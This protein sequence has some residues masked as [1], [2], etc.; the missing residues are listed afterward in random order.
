MSVTSTSKPLTIAATAEPIK[1]IS[2]EDV[3]IAFGLPIMTAIAWLAPPSAWMGVSRAFAPIYGHMPSGRRQGLIECIERY[4]GDRPAATDA[5]TV[6]KK[7]PRFEIWNILQYMRHYRPGGWRPTIRFSGQEHI[8]EGLAQGRGVIIWI[9]HFVYCALITLMGFHGAGFRLNQLSYPT[10]GFSST[11]FGMRVLNPIQGAIENRFL[12]RRVEMG[13]DDG[14][15][16][17]AG[18]RGALQENRVISL[19]VRNIAR[20]PLE[21]PFFDGMI[22]MAVGAP[23]LAYTTGAT[24][25][26]VFTLWDEDDSGAFSVT[27]EPPLEVRSDVERGEALHRGARQYARLLESYVLRYPD[28][29]LGWSHL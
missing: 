20:R 14:S 2:G 12:G 24:L 7:L 11:R 5:A 22:S 9:S 25:L 18:L 15:G 3:A 6:A 1:L 23:Y 26:P 29:W 10:H 4:L 13:L 16:A 28:Q 19:A 17:I 21:V 8:E 27:V